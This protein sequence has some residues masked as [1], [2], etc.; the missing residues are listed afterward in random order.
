MVFFIF[1]ISDDLLAKDKNELEIFAEKYL[2]TFQDKLSYKKFRMI[3]AILRDKKKKLDSLL[4]ADYLGKY[5]ATG[6]EYINNLKKIIKQ[7]SLR[8]FDDARLMPST[9]QLKSLI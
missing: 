9:Y 4:L 3:R 5:A 2:E 6:D 1:F 7:N 8:D